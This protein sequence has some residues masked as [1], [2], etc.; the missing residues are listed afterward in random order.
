MAG[1]IVAQ[2]PQNTWAPVCESFV[3]SLKKGWLKKGVVVEAANREIISSPKGHT[4]G[5]RRPENEARSL[6]RFRWLGLTDGPEKK[7]EQMQP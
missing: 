3:G 5:V 2:P 6:G 7:K 4:Q 1:S